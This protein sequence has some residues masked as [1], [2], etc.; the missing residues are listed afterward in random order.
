M[1]RVTRHEMI[2][3]RALQLSETTHR[4]CYRPVARADAHPMFEAG[5]DSDFHRYLDW[6]KPADVDGAM[7]RLD[8]LLSEELLN[9]SV[10]SSIVDKPTGQWMGM[11]R[12]VPFRSG[13][14]V[15]LW[16]RP[17]LWLHGGPGE[18]LANALGLVHRITTLES[19]YALVDAHDNRMALLVR[20]HGMK[21]VAHFDST[22]VFCLERAVQYANGS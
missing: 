7:V 22:D 2:A 5:L 18:I 15:E 9:T 20:Q 8:G 13:L 4:F 1:S 17:E 6:S 19:L 3:I 11:L 10:T 16:L 14:A 21:P 12:W